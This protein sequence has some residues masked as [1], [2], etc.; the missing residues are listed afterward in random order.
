LAGLAL[1][2]LVVFVLVV[3]FLSLLDL[4]VFHPLRHFIGRTEPAF[5]EMTIAAGR[6]NRGSIA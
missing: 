3:L 6:A 4:S 5:A 2:V 1:I